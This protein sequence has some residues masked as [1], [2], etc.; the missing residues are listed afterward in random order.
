M[1]SEQEIRDAAKI[2]DTHR[3]NKWGSLQDNHDLDTAEF[4]WLIVALALEWSIDMHDPNV[5]DEYQPPKL[6]DG[7]IDDLLEKQG[8]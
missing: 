3:L 2:V 7:L 8:G 6:F 1:K 4:G 5:P